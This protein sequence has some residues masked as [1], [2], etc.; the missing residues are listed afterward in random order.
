MMCI[1]VKNLF[2]N[3]TDVDLYINVYSCCAHHVNALE[4]DHIEVPFHSTFI[5]TKRL[6]T[7]VYISLA[8]L[9]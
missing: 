5:K 6:R 7:E 1:Y 3:F 8:V 2:Q 4:K 9:H